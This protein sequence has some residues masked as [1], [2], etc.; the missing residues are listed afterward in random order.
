MPGLTQPLLDLTATIATAYVASHLLPA[1]AVGGLI[2]TIGGT[3]ANLAGTATGPVERQGRAVSAP[4]APA[5]PVERS[6]FSNF[7][8]C[9]QCG[10]HRKA[11]KRHLNEAHGLDLATYRKNWNLPSS[12]PTTAPSYSALRS[13]MA[14]DSGLGKGKRPLT[15]RRAR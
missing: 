14:K 2:E 13:R 10:A 15:K 11:L 1:P 3:L 8:V 6:V 7:I 5:V 12:Y 4:V 9:L